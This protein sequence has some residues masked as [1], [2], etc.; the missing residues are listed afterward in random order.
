MMEQSAEAGHKYATRRHQIGNASL[1]L[2]KRLFA[3]VDVGDKRMALHACT[4]ASRAN[5]WVLAIAAA[6][7]VF[8]LT[9]YQYNNKCL[10][11]YDEFLGIEVGRGGEQIEYLVVMCVS[12]AVFKFFLFHPLVIAVLGTSRVFR[13]LRGVPITGTR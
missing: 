8:Y 10:D 7:T 12:A 9:E 13:H 1:P 3:D 4:A 6:A 5:E 11:K 2:Y